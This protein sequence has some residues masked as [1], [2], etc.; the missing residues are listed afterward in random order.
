MQFTSKKKRKTVFTLVKSDIV[1]TDNSG[2]HDN[3]THVDRSLKRTPKKEK[4]AILNLPLKKKQ[5]QMHPHKSE[6]VLTPT[7][8]QSNDSHHHK[9]AG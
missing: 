3:H 9:V 5:K 6:T 1:L 7:E 2:N 8:E 4:A